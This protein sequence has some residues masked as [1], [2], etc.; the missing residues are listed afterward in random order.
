MRVAETKTWSADY[1][2]DLFREK[3]SPEELQ[4]MRDELYEQHCEFL[5]REI[6]ELMKR[7]TPDGGAW[8]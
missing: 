2:G 5:N 6:E 7:G 3:P 4:R 1:L 8:G